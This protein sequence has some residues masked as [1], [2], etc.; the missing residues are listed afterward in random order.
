MTERTIRL[1]ERRAK[2]RVALCPSAYSMDGSSTPSPP[3]L[4]HS[5]PS[6]FELLLS[7]RE[8]PVS[9]GARSPLLLAAFLDCVRAARG[10]RH[11][12]FKKKKKKNEITLLLVERTTGRRSEE[13]SLAR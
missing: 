2:P 12:L 9:R 8:T 6:P 13:S 7:I 4:D 11:T 1:E 3:I 10:D 5:Q